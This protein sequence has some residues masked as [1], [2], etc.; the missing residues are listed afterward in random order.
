MDVER[1]ARLKKKAHRPLASAFRK[2]LAGTNVMAI[3]VEMFWPP[4]HDAIHFLAQ[5]DRQ[6]ADWDFSIPTEHWRLASDPDGEFPEGLYDDIK[7]LFRT[8]WREARGTGQG[9]R[10]YL[11][12]HDSLWSVDLATG[13]EV[14]DRDRPDYVEPDRRPFSRGGRPTRRSSR[15]GELVRRGD[16]LSAVKRAYRT[17]EEPD[18]AR[19]QYLWPERGIRIEIKNGRVQLIVYF[20][21]FMDCVCGIWIGAHAWEVDDIL[22]RAK[23]ESFHSTGRI[24][25]YDVDGFLSV[26][27]DRGDRVVSICR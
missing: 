4:D 9:T 18:P 21:P 17:A 10:A 15:N 13:R 1:R 12:M 5:V 19:S 6:E 27:F 3:D 20:K 25:Q 22:G 23:A 2:L 26:G 14:W 24:W 16:P 8:A 11:R 7:H